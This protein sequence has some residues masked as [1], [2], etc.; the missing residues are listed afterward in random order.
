M[1]NSIPYSNQT[2]WLR[3][4][5]QNLRDTTDETIAENTWV[6]RKREGEPGIILPPS[7]KYLNSLSQGRRETVEDNNSWLQAHP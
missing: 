7:E 6:I 1:G 4:D 2:L 5:Q 3:L